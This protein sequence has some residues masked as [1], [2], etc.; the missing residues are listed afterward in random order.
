M[1]SPTELRFHGTPVDP[2]VADLIEDRVGWLRRCGG[3]KVYV[4][5]YRPDERFVVELRVRFGGRLVSLSTASMSHSR[6]VDPCAAV[7]DLFGALDFPLLE[8]DKLQAQP[9]QGGQPRGG[10]VVP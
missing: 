1:D 8:A 7:R 3:R 4:D 9:G 10:P 5:V 6:H 2:D